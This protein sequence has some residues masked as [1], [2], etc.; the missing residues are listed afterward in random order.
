MTAAG[1]VSV[2]PGK[3]FTVMICLFN[4]ENNKTKDKDHDKHALLLSPG[5]G[6][7]HSRV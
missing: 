6:G 1:S 2:I 4:L 5:K 3:L 7:G